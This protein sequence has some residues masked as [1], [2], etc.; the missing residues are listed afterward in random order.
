M[1]EEALAPNVATTVALPDSAKSPEGSCTLPTGYLDE[2]G[3]LHTTAVVKEL[4]GE[5]EDILMSKRLPAHLKMQRVMENC[6]L[7]IGSH[8]AG[9]DSNWTDVLQSLTVTDRLFLIIQI[10]MTSLGNAYTFKTKCPNQQCN[11]LQEKVVDLAEFVINGMPDPDKRVWTGTLPKS[12]L[13]YRAKIQTG[14]DEEK[15]F[16]AETATKDTVTLAMLARMQELDGKMPVTL[17]MLKKLG[18]E[19]RNHLRSEFKKHEGKL[20][21]VVDVTCNDCAQEFKTAIDVAQESFF[22]LSAT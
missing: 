5:E 14:A 3:V 12:K 20:D 15:L 1:S 19:D 18:A 10:R 4:T 7:S 22:F 6:V 17:G 16:K 8:S 2:A 21:N 11:H 9:E 13:T